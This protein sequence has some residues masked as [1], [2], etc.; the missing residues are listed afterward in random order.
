MANRN[1]HRVQSLSRELKL[2]NAKV[3]VASNVATVD[4]NLSVG[5]E[6]VV[7]SATGVVTVTLQDKYNAF[8]FASVQSIGSAT[9]DSHFVCTSEDVA[10]SKVIVFQNVEAGVAA[11]IDDCELV[12]K[13]ELKNSSVSK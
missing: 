8:I 3:T 10:S 12:I 11:D 1:F 6:S 2:V 9:V 5:V 4:K 7:I 13:L